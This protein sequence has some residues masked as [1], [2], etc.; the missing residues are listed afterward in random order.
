[1]KKSFQEI[2][3]ADTYPYLEAKLREDVFYRI[4]D[5]IKYP[6]DVSL[7]VY[8]DASHNPNDGK[9]ENE[10]TIKSDEVYLAPQVMAI[11]FMKKKC[12]KNRMGYYFLV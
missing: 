11:P 4:G 9:V 8:F 7:G 5:G 3:C 10:V 12:S 6:F 1:M 2:G